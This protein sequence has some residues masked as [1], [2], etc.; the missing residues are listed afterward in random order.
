M[1]AKA[2]TA[3]VRAEAQTVHLLAEAVAGHSPNRGVGLTGVA[4]V[5]VDRAPLVG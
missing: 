5:A 4:V 3:V 2:E 1:A